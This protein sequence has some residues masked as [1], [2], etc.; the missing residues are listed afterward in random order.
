ML[1]LIPILRERELDLPIYSLSEKKNRTKS[2]FVDSNRVDTVS[3]PPEFLDVG[4]F[5]QSDD[6]C[7]MIFKTWHQASTND[8][9]IVSLSCSG[10]EEIKLYLKRFFEGNNLGVIVKSESNSHFGFFEIK[11]KLNECI[12]FKDIRNA[13]I[14]VLERF[15][16]SD[17]DIRGKKLILRKKIRNEKN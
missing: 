12:T 17:E 5:I 1:N 3:I 10:N 8:N 6:F 13:Y 14:S 16:I 9:K 2:T 4:K 11:I 15:H 7:E